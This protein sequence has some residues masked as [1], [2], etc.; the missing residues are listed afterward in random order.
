MPGNIS[1]EYMLGKISRTDGA[2]KK[3]PNRQTVGAHKSFGEVLQGIKGEVKFSKHA[4]ERLNQ[5]DLKLSE[6][7]LNTISKAFDEAETKGIRDA[8][9][10]IG[11]NLMV[12]SVRNRTIVTA[13]QSQQEQAKIITNIDGAIVL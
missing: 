8:V 9:V 1:N 13:L 5:R 3:Q 2:D 11:G 12:A 7:D 10:L 4:M 6:A